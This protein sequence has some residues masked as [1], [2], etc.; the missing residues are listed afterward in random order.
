MA[1]KCAIP[2]RATI[3]RESGRRTFNHST[4]SKS[5]PCHARGGNTGVTTNYFAKYKPKLRKHYMGVKMGKTKLLGRPWNK[6]VETIE[7]AFPVPIVKVT[8]R[9]IHRKIANI[10]DPL[11]LASLVTLAGKMLYIE[12]CDARVPWDCG[13][14]RELKIA[15]ENWERVLTG[16]VEVLRSQVR[17]QRRKLSHNHKGSTNSHHW[18]KDGH[19][20]LMQKWDLWTTIWVGSWVLRFIR[21]CRANASR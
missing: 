3:L 16:K 2:R 5:Q 14:P 6:T 20:E 1:F 7:V 10:Y 9:E 15:W 17:P 18:N 8:Y 11:G 21:N 4:G 19:D 13:V 12:T